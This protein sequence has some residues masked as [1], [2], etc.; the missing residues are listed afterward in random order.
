MKSDTVTKVVE[1]LESD[2][3]ICIDAKIITRILEDLVQH[4]YLDNLKEG[5]IVEIDSELK[6]GELSARS[7]HLKV[8]FGL[9]DIETVGRHARRDIAKL[10]HYDLINFVESN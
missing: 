5:E 3:D 1:L 2:F 4:F 8:K 6:E 9:E 10:V 7:W